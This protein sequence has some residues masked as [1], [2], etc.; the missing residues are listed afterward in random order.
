MKAIRAKFLA[1]RFRTFMQAHPA[2]D[3]LVVGRAPTHRLMG[4]GPND[5]DA[6][7]LSGLSGLPSDPCLTPLDVRHIGSV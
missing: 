2:Q 7:A 3:K 6:S 5:P 4:D 1:G